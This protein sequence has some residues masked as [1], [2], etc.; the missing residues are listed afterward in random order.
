ML[1]MSQKRSKFDALHDEMF[2]HL[3]ESV[4]DYAIFLLDTDGV[5]M[6]WNPGAERIKGYAAQDIIGRH[7]SIF[8]PPDALATGFPEYELTIARTEGRYENDGWRLRK[9]GS[10]FW[11]HVTLN[12]VRNE[13]GSLLGYAKVTRDLTPQR[14]QE[15]L[16]RESEE[17][18]QLLVESV[19]DYAIFMLDVDGYI[20]SWNAGAHNIKGYTADEIIGKHFS[21]FYTADAI[22]RGWPQKELEIA[23]REGRLEDVGWRV[24]KDG[25]L[26]WADVVITPIYER[27]GRLR[28]YSKVT[29]DMTTRRHIEELEQASRNMTQFLAM[30]AHELRNPLAPI[31]N[32]VHVMESR[33]S[34]AT[35]DARCREIIDRQ[36]SQ[37]VRL[38]DD[39]LDATRITTGKIELR[40]SPVDMNAL[41]GRGLEYVDREKHDIEVQV[42][43]TPIVVEGD[44]ARLL[45]IISNLLNNAT[46]YTEAGGRIKCTLERVGSEVALSVRDEGIGIAPD[47]LPHIFELFKQGEGA[48]E[49]GSGGLGVGLALVKTLT[50]LHGGSVE[51]QS[52]GPGLGSEFRVTLPAL[53]AAPQRE[54]SAQGAAPGESAAKRILVVDDNRDAA[55]T[56]AAILKAWGHTVESAFDGLAGVSAAIAFRPQIVLLDIGLPKLNGYDVARRLKRL[57]GLGDVFLIAITGYGQEE[58]RRQARDAGFDMHLVKPVDPGTLM[59]TIAAAV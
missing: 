29:R 58:D 21:V 13:E 2:R 43:A 24:R 4:R 28:G 41:V 55:E 53:D 10:R 45:Q 42:P 51:A 26:F 40:R 38:V 37:L 59:K 52:P 32:A 11:A 5:V 14:M 31:R 8:Y 17:R 34:D 22:R 44:E 12:A 33:P 30:L 9:D 56:M 35:N 47:L 36:V 39:L 18:F 23:L 15:K 1:P 54:P 3:A 49:R 46:K 48:L 6:T 27:S 19:K 16:L 20:M 50:L 57:P 25:T 7:F